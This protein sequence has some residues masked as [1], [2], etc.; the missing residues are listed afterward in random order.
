MNKNIMSIEEE[1]GDATGA[2][3]F[4][5]LNA[6]KSSQYTLNG[7]VK[8]KHILGTKSGATSGQAP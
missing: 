8:A 6:D 5:T 3:L 7:K 1:G 4:Y 2:S